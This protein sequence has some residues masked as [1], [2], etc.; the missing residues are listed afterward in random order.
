MTV[1]RTPHTLA[2]FALLISLGASTPVAAAPWPLKQQASPVHAAVSDDDALPHAAGKRARKQAAETKAAK[3]KADAE[4][5]PPWD[6]NKP[7]GPSKTTVIDTTAGTWMNLDVSP[8]GKTIVFDLL[9]D[10]Y[11]LPITG[12]EA[13]ALTSGL[14]WDM[15]PR[16]S[17]DGA[18]IAYTSDAGGGDN[19]WIMQRDGSHATAVTEERFRLLNNAVWS[20]DGQYLAARKHF[21][22]RRS[23]GAGE[24][25]LYH[26]S[27]GAGLQLTEKPNDQKDT[28]EPA[29]SPDGRYIYF[30][31]DTTPGPVFAYNKDPSSGIYQILRL[32]RETGE[33]ETFIEE[34]GGSVRPTPSPDGTRL[35]YVGRDRYRTAL[36][37]VDL[38]SDARH[39]LTNT[40][41]R[42]LQETWAIHGVYANFA[43]TPDSRAIIY[44]AG[45]GLH[46]IDVASHAITDIPFHVRQEHTVIEALRTPVDPAPER[47]HTKMLR[48]VEVS[49]DGESVLF[50]AL[51]KIWIRDRTAGEPRRLTRQDQHFELYPAFSRDGQQVVYVSWDD[52]Q[53]G[54]VRIVPV[55][56][57]DEGRT[58]TRVPGHYLKPALSPDGR[59]VIYRKIAGGFLSKPLYGHDLGLYALATD[60]SGP[61]HRLDPTGPAARGFAVHFGASSERV[62]FTTHE[63]GDK[64]M[65]RS[66]ALDGTHPREHALSEAAT[67]FRVSP[68]GHWLAFAERFHAFIAPLPDIGKAIE[69]GPKTAGLPVARVSRDAGEYLRWSGD[70]QSLHWTLG[71]KLFSRSLSDSFA[72]L[73]GAPETLPEPETEGVDIGFEVT[74]DVPTGRIALVGARI[75]TMKG[76]QVVE[77]GTVVV[78]GDRIVAVGPRAEVSVPEDT[79]IIDANGQ[80][81]IPGIIDVHWHGS[82][83]F[84]EI[85]PEQNW[86]NFA[87]LAF[88]VTTIHDP[89]NDTSTFFA[90]AEMAR[91]GL[92]T[93]P[94]MFSTGTILYGA[95]GDF[96]AEIDSI[97][98]AREHLRRMKAVGAISVKSYNQPRREQRQQ[99]L[100][101]AR[102]LD[103]MVVP[104]GG[105]L[106]MHNMTM[107]VD[108]HTGVEHAIPLAHLYDDVAQLWSSTSVGYTPTLVVA[109]G[110]WWGENYW[111]QTTDVY[112]DE[113]LL[114][115]VPRPFIEP[116]ARRRE[117]IPAEELNHIRVSEGAKML[118][119]RGVLV[120]LGAHG[121]REG[122]GAHWELWMFEQGGMTPMEALRTATLNGAKYLGMDQHLG[123]IEVGKL[124]DL[125][126]L[127]KNPLENLRDSTSVVY[128][129]VGGRLYDAWTLNQVGNHPHQRQP[130][131]WE[132]TQ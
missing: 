56:G 26:R 67:E 108:G 128:T 28:G 82:Q 47:F 45:G 24:I 111:Y 98:D 62:F 80:T 44:W 91:A 90:A 23:L 95:G 40:L 129:M 41:D 50:E 115:F 29:F 122:L 30:S 94:R 16:F 11:T 79:M 88:G 9:G 96:K 70:G 60:G 32:D 93:A 63:S 8:D 34:N 101:A 48:S 6:V 68:D 127:A 116:R 119:D 75:I 81:I 17:P 21:T 104:E 35:A 27:G 85:I 59:T 77:D 39:M 57:A 126:V 25:W 132:E 55:A 2:T 102:E 14:A 3:A 92:I 123:S 105:S 110:G 10:L 18:S 54:A 78:E 86:F 31:R 100:Q 15:Q 33:V 51:G 52:A 113:R 99:I 120:E 69:I 61:A 5:T 118:A 107:V 97:E 76:E 117:K 73:D 74:T 125:V 66:I 1:T 22:A 38:E 121:Q 83:G 20:P 87:A 124:A 12:G 71:P 72:F 131:F 49:P 114:S 46:R 19:I 130:L 89:S 37:V 13:T 106:F 36:F 65:L 109:Y 42:D 7:F 64:R 53:L 84:S 58:L 112:A 4:E 103:M 43:W